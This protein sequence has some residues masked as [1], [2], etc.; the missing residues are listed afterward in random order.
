MVVVLEM[1][2]HRGSGRVSVIGQRNGDKYLYSS[3]MVELLYANQSQSP[4]RG[5]SFSS[6]W[7]VRSAV[8]N[9]R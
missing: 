2:V 3:S 6:I 5:S 4:S 7:F 9:E 8:C 1:T